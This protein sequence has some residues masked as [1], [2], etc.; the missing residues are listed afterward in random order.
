MADLIIL[1]KKG[2]SGLPGLRGEKGKWFGAL[3]PALCKCQGTHTDVSFQGLLECLATLASLETRA[4]QAC[5]VRAA[6]RASARP[7]RTASRATQACRVTKASA[8][9]GV[10]LVWT[11]GL[12]PLVGQA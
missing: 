7:G 2:D 12:G 1:N 3:S 4:G 5:R 11:E 9:G 10:N 6:P 8:A